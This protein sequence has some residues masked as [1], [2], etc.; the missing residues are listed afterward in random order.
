MCTDFGIVRFH[1][2]I[3]ARCFANLQMPY[4]L[5]T[6]SLRSTYFYGSNGVDF[7]HK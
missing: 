1:Q 4:L 2:P 6:V 3:T 7:E 5:G